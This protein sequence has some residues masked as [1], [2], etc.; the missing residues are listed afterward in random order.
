M[1]ITMETN[2]V[3]DQPPGVLEAQATGVHQ[4]KL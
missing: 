3:K 4:C 2:I 1:L